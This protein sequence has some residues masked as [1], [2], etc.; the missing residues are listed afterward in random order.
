MHSCV[1]LLLTMNSKTTL[2]IIRFIFEMYVLQHAYSN[3]D[4]ARLKRDT[5]DIAG[6]G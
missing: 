1:T 6:P 2:A 5:D 3:R 4:L